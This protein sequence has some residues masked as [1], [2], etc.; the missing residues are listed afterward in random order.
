M[1][2]LINRLLDPLADFGPPSDPKTSKTSGGF[3]R[4]T[5]RPL[6]TSGVFG[7]CRHEC[8]KTSGGFNG[9]RGRREE[10][11]CGCDEATAIK[12]KKPPD[13]L[14]IVRKTIKIFRGFLR[15]DSATLKNLRGFSMMQRRKMQ[16]CHFPS[17][18]S[19]GFQRAK[20]AWGRS[21]GDK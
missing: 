10:E 13:F 3:V 1:A 21:T 17:V 4:F 14:W 6:K 2:R 18:F 15:V 9:F 20:V 7:G 12:L 8:L 19:I 16:N 5:R 11:K